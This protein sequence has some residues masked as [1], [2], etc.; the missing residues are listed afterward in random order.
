VELAMT[1][2]LVATLEARL[3][4]EASVGVDASS[5]LPSCGSVPPIRPS[6]T[7]AYGPE[8]DRDDDQRD[9]GNVFHGVPPFLP[10][11]R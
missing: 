10:S 1:L 11:P 8:D 5:D 6:L 4:L 3:A 7:R 9:G 2:E